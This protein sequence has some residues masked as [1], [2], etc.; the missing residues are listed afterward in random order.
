[1][2][3]VETQV[4]TRR[5]TE[6]LDEDSYHRMQLT[7]AANP[8]AGVVIRGSGGI[9]K[10]RWAGSGR[11]KRGGVR[12]IYYWWTAL[13]RISMLLIYRKNEQDDLTAE[14]L[15]SMKRALSEGA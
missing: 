3:F 5:V 6:L 14:Q 1:V 11:G 13:D 7:L 12:V 4:F 8:L 9:R 15:K 2:V 10:F